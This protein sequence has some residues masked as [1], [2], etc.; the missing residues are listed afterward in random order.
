MIAKPTNQ[1][2]DNPISPI[3]KSRDPRYGAIPT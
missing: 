3:P 1:P 2:A